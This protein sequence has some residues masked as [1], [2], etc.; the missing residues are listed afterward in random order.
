MERNNLRHLIF[1]DESGWDNDNRYASLALVSGTFDNTNEL[2]SQLKNILK[3]HDK[4]E[5]RFSKIKNNNSVN[6]AY[7]F[8]ERGF[9][10]LISSKIKVHI[11]VWDKHDSRHDVIG[12]CDIENL[13]MMYYKV[14]L[15]L[16]RHWNVNTS[17]EFYPDEFTAINWSNDIVE[18]LRNT[19]L[20]K[21]IQHPQLFEAFEQVIFPKYRIVQELVS[22]KYP[23]IQ[24]A[25][26]YAGI[27]RTSRNYSEDFFKWYTFKKTTEQPTLFKVDEPNISKSI[28]PKF[29]LM[30]KFKNKA[31]RF[32]MGVNL[33]D[34][35][36]FSKNHKKLNLFIWHYEPQR[37]DDKAPTKKK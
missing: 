18:F 12:R 34:K 33:S 6:I 20:Q 32:K 14:L 7:S 28:I 26:L 22:T 29:E 36:Y 30:Y 8:L 2:N 37:E 4:E 25:D 16:K 31:D 1:S 15:V 10:Y 13:K 9:E 27:I 23:I 11:L 35:K 19:P 5:I 17:W 3:K 21:K 24:L